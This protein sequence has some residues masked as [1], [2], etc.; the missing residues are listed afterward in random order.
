MTIGH[1]LPRLLAGQLK[2]SYSDIFREFNYD[3]SGPEDEEED[4]DPGA[5]AMAPLPEG[6]EALQKASAWY[7]VSHDVGKNPYLEKARTEQLG[8]AGEKEFTQAPLLFLSFPW[9]S[10]YEHLCAIKRMRSKPTS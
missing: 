9:V 6:M 7:V 10:A 4:N 8:G 5:E 1:V 2:V 3:D